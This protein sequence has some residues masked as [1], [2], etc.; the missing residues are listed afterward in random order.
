M[1]HFYT[2][3]LLVLFVG[4]TMLTSRNLLL[5][6]SKQNLVIIVCVPMFCYRGSSEKSQCCD[7]S[8]E[9]QKE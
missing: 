1:Q 8:R 5:I 9:E 2:Q 7:R 4:C 3:L 6:I